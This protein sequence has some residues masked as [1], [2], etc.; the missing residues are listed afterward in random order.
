[1]IERK[2]QGQHSH[3]Y[4]EESAFADFNACALAQKE[5]WKSIYSQTAVMRFET[6]RFGGMVHRSDS[7]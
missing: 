6:Q 4:L 1:M 5:N 3:P 7:V 2:L